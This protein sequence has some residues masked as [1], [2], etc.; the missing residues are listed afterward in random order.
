MFT[1][2]RTV[3]SGL[4]IAVSNVTEGHAAWKQVIRVM[5]DE[6]FLVLEV[7]RQRQHHRPLCIVVPHGG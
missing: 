5:E 3:A 7:G 6:L 1:A 4:P 2:K